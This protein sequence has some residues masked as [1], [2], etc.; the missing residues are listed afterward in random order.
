MTGK[1]LINFITENQLEDAPIHFGPHWNTLEFGTWKV[2]DGG[3]SDSITYTVGCFKSNSKEV[4][5][6]I[7]L[8][9]YGDDWHHQTSNPS[10]KE[11]LKIRKVVV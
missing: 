1:D 7:E 10:P 6:E 5:S 3:P 8:F 4:S 2:I 11:A 9:R